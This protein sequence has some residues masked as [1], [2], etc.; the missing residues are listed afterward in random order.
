MDVIE[1]EF[2]TNDGADTDP[3][4][5]VRCR[6]HRFPGPTHCPLPAQRGGLVELTDSHRVVGE[7]SRSLDIVEVPPAPGPEFAFE[8]LVDA[9]SDRGG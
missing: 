8:V 2:P 1:T 3:H 4:P 9:L 5:S 6:R 7:L